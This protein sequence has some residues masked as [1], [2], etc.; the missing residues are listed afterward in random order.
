VAGKLNCDLLDLRAF[1][2]LHE[3]R[4][5]NRAARLLGM[6]QPALSR[7]IQR[8]EGLIGASLFD[9]TS[10]TLAETALGKELLP[11]ASLTLEQLDSSLFALP[12]LRETRW[13]DITIFCIQTAAFHMLPVAAQRFLEEHPRVRLRILDMLAVEGA[14]MVARGEAEFG[15]SIESLLP[16]GL[17]FEALHDDQFGLV[18]GRNHPLAKREVVQWSELKGESLIAVHRASRTAV[19]SSQNRTLLD[20]ELNRHGVTVEWRFEVGHLTTALGMIE[21]GI[22]VAVMPRMVIP[23]SERSGVAWRPLAGPVVE[24]TVG[25]VQRRSD[26]MHPA[27]ARLLECLREEW[28]GAAPSAS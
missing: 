21:S 28:P 19:R 11:I 20:A 12:K 13:T 7:R 14:D 26:S 27:A 18:C 1:V 9:R 16:P 15:I 4:S 17:K 24:R 2:A 22:G 10:R 25:I 8:L 5:F 23:Q 3:T 6:S